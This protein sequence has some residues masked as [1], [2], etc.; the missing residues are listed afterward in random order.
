MEDL[1]DSYEDFDFDPDTE[2][3]D[4]AYLPDPDDEY[5]YDERLDFDRV[6]TLS[7]WDTD[8]DPDNRPTVVAY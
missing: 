8:Y 7:D 5:G 1:F 3:D 2:W 4:S 6:G